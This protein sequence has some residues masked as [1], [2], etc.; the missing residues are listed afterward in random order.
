MDLNDRQH[1]ILAV[2]R[3]SGR[4]T[5]DDLAARFQVTPQTIRKDLN[6]LCE[7]RL[8]ARTHG[9]AVVT[10][11]VEN[12]AY[13]ARRLIADAEKRAIGRAAAELIPD[14]CSLFINIGTT[15]EEVAKALTDRRDLLVITNNLHVAMQLYPSPSIKVIVA[16]GQ[17]RHSDGAVIGA[18]AIDLIQQFK[19]DLAVIGTS[20]IDADGALLDFDYQEVRVSQAIIENARKVI[21]VSDHLKMGRAAPVRIAHITQVDVFVTDR[22]ASPELAKVCRDA[23]VEI[24]ETG[25]PAAP[26]TV[27]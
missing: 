4:V 7:Q 13:A 12:V 14:N 23:G 9:G 19:V 26:G 22:M 15:T 8:L 2:A 16:G 17:V 1:E 27:P 11:S 21:L 5:V 6:D 18:S 24:I 10:S 25:M 3:A 20:A